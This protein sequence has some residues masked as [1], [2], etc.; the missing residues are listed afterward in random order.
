MGQKV[1]SV[2][3]PVAE[4]RLFYVATQ[5]RIVTTVPL[6]DESRKTLAEE[7]EHRDYFPDIIKAQAYVTETEKRIVE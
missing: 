3:T 6:D 2:G 5:V 1:I 7:H 4:G